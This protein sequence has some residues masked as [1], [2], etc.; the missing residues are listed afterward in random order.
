MSS[1]S[2]I[3]LLVL[4]IVGVIALFAILKIVFKGKSFVKENQDNLIKAIFLL[5]IVVSLGLTLY[6]TNA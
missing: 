6:F 4:L 2:A 5:G 1:L 3:L